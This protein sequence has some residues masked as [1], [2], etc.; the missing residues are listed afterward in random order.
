M[1]YKIVTEVLTPITSMTCTPFIGVTTPLP[2]NN[3]F[4][5]LANEK[6]PKTGKNKFIY[7]NF[8]VVCHECSTKDAKIMSQC[9]HVVG[10]MNPW[11]SVAKQDQ[12]QGTVPASVLLQ[13]QR[14]VA[15]DSSCVYDT[16]SIEALVTQRDKKPRDPA[17]YYL[18]YDPNF[19]GTSKTAIMICGLEDGLVTVSFIFVCICASL[20]FSVEDSRLL[21]TNQYGQ[22]ECL[23]KT[24]RYY[25][26]CCKLYIQD[27][28]QFEQY[29]VTNEHMPDVI[30]QIIVHV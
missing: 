7:I 21:P 15:L 30:N 8:E 23:K 17:F 16:D 20:L 13:E 12:W 26:Y 9:K 18:M 28:G 11:R 10:L 6:D 27:V 5:V 19:G 24:F 25:R 29:A 4:T 1:E 14:G 2:K 3:W 22:K